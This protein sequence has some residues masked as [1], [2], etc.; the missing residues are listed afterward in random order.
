MF[1]KTPAEPTALEKAIVR[2]HDDMLAEDPDTDKYAKMADNLTKLYKLRDHDTVKRWRPSPDVA[3]T[4]AANILG[5]VMIIKHE[6]VN[7]IT[8]KAIGFVVKP[9]N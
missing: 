1:K 5:I 2:L 6:D 4:V 9:K 8:S 3:L 7:V